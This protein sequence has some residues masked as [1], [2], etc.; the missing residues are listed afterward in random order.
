L[1]G[2]VVA[3]SLFLNPRLELDREKHAVRANLY[4]LC[5]DQIAKRFQVLYQSFAMVIG[6]QITISAIN[7]V[8]TAIFVM[9]VGCLMRR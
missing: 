9:V 5:C 4:S 7:T 3:I 6:A 1:V 8:L 2:C